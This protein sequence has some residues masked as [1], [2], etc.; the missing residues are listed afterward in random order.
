MS[1]E[2]AEN[3]LDETPMPVRKANTESSRMDETAQPKRKR[4]RKVK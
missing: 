4:T 2:E 1:R 3:D